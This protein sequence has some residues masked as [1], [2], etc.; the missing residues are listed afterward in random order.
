MSKCPLAEASLQQNQSSWNFEDLVLGAVAI[1][2]ESVA[3][4]LR[5]QP[6]QDSDTEEDEGDHQK[7][8]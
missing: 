3:G 4:C 5:K 8:D 6:L 7:R 2:A 1:T